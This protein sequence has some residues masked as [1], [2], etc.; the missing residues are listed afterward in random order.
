MR[1][2]GLILAA[3]LSTRAQSYKMTLPFDDGTVLE[4]V[5]KRMEA[6]C[7]RII[8]VGGYRHELL[9]PICACY[10]KVVL[11]INEHY[12]EGM[13]SSIKCGLAHLQCDRFFMSPGDYPLVQAEVYEQMLKTEDEVVIPIYRGRSGHP[14]LVAGQY[15]ETCLQNTGYQTMRDFIKDRQVTYVNVADKGI[16]LD[17]DTLNDYEAALRRFQHADYR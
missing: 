8:V 11:V 15:I 13:F 2:E 3:G 5:I 14:I 10:P 4:R 17:I 1:I 7:E 12:E 6:Y 9:V 16:L